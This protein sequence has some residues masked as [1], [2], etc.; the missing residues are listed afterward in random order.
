MVLHCSG[1]CEGYFGRSHYPE[2]G[3]RVDQ[4]G[5]T[6]ITDPEEATGRYIAGFNVSTLDNEF[7]VTLTWVGK[8]IA[9]IEYLEGSGRSCT[10][11]L[12]VENEVDAARIFI[13]AAP[14][15][16][17]LAAMQQIA[18][19][20]PSRSALERMREVPAYDLAIESDVVVLASLQELQP[21]G[22]HSLGTGSV[23]FDMAFEQALQVK[24]SW[25][26][27]VVRL[28]DD[29]W[30]RQVLHALVAQLCMPVPQEWIEAPLT[31]MTEA[32]LE[33]MLKLA[34]E[35]RGNF[36]ELYKAAIAL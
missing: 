24:Q 12:P 14:E 5:K 25:F 31:P 6:D 17:Q 29:P 3:R 28:H 1:V 8:G 4:I 20:M 19:P 27:Q 16:V 35:W 13:A 9:V 22:A 7:A 33:T 21:G 36:A 32:A 10:H 2:I 15:S 11:H 23:R 18:L 30:G 26:T 34:P